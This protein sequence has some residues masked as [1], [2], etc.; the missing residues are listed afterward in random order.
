MTVTLRGFLIS[1][2]YCLFFHLFLCYCR[3]FDI[4]FNVRNVLSL[5]A[6]PAVV[7]LVVSLALVYSY[8]IYSHEPSSLFH[9]CV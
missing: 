8:G 4:R 2:A 5:M 3:Y 9:H 7:Q 1:I 6:G